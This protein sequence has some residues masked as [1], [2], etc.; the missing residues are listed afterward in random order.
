MITDLQDSIQSLSAVLHLLLM[1]SGLFPFQLSVFVS[2]TQKWY[3]NK[4]KQHPKKIPL[5]AASQS[6]LCHTPF[7]LCQAMSRRSPKYKNSKSICCSFE[8][9]SHMA[10]ASQ[11]LLYLPLYSSNSQHCSVENYFSCNDSFGIWVMQNR[12]SMPVCG[13]KSQQFSSLISAQR[14]Q[15][16]LAAVYFTSHHKRGG[17][18]LSARDV[19]A[20]QRRGSATGLR[21]CPTSTPKGGERRKHSLIT[22]KRCLACGADTASCRQCRA[23]T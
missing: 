21:E 12:W 8:G 5:E 15:Q 23:V 22:A 18:A 13:R 14:E 20:V 11:T 2:W 7:S 9:C 4:T 1:I 3:C 16:F 10:W 17:Q 6:C 19:T